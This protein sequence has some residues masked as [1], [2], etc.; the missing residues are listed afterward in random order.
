MS[1]RD[2]RT[3]QFVSGG[4]GGNLPG[5]EA[6]EKQRIGLRYEMNAA[7]PAPSLH[8]QLV[9]EAPAGGLDRGE[10]AELVAF[11]VVAEFRP[12]AAGDTAFSGLATMEV[13]TAPDSQYLDNAESVFTADVDGVTGIDR[14]LWSEEVDA[15][16]IDVHNLSGQ[17][18]N[19]T[20]AARA[21]N[22]HSDLDRTINFPSEYGGG[23]VLDRHDSVFW[24]FHI[25]AIGSTW[26]GE[27][28][29]DYALVWAVTLDE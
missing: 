29:F 27:I 16:T 23:P 25:D 4:G 1:A 26:Q 12:S 15:D 19:H 9:V 20:T 22:E 24:H 6:L 11:V 5:W 7:S 3:G 2:P 8:E 21:S 10:L 14:R 18:S 28:R 17:Q 13:T